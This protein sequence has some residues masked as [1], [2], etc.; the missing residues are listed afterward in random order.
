MKEYLIRL[1]N[2]NHWA[3]ES[4]IEAIEKNK[5]TEASINKNIS[6]I[7]NAQYVW[8]ARFYPKKKFNYQIWDIHNTSKLKE[9]NDEISSFYIEYIS[10]IKPR[11]LTDKIEYITTN[12]EKYFNTLFDIFIHIANHS[13][14]HRGQIT[15]KISDL[16]L[17]APKVDY[18]KYCRTFPE[19]W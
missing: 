3:N 8:F 19:F 17:E 10:K 4:I 6:H 2:F 9:M 5:I 14:H 1:F 18:I 13:A 11:D 16:K 12:E 15:Y 7:L